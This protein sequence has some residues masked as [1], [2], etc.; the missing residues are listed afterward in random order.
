MIK[1]NGNR[2]PFS[3]EASGFKKLGLLALLV[4]SGQLET[5]SV[6]F[7]DEPENSL[8][9]EF[10]PVLVDIL[11]ELSRNDVQIFIATHSEM[12]AR[13]FA[14]NRNKDDMVMFYSLFKDREQIKV[15][16]DNRFDLLKPNNLKSEIVKLYEKE[17]ERGLGGNA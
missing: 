3:H 16:A 7:W 14:V 17:V 6:L 2:I 1:S 15:N 8:N 11:L 10:I 4:T 12:I 9:P 13:Y 5:D